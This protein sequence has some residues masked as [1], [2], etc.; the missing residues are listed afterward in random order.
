MLNFLYK[1]EFYRNRVIRKLIHISRRTVDRIDGIRDRKTCGVPLSKYVPSSAAGATGS[2]STPYPVLETIYRDAD[3][4]AEESFLDVGCGKGRVLAFLLKKKCRWKLTGIELNKAVA[5]FA[6]SWTDA[7]PEIE[8]IC[9]NA[10]EL[11]YDPYTVLHLGR[12]FEENLFL[13][14][15]GQ[16]ERTLTHPIKLYY[17]V[18]QESGHMLSGR[19]G[20][21]R[22]CRKILFFKKGFFIAMTP[23]TY[24]V[25]TYKPDER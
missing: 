10:L 2:Q 13:Q 7:Y 14:F 16:L 15:V 6:K 4:Q 17:W 12:P 9:G 21:T 23:Q 18:E 25:W 20:W 19:P 8:L 3:F 1:E 22:E 5:D 24:S 11:N